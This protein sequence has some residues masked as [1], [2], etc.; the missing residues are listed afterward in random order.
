MRPEKPWQVRYKRNLQTNVL[1]S[2]DS[3]ILN[4]ISKYNP[5]IYR[6]RPRGNYSRNAKLLKDSNINIMYLIIK[7]KKLYDHYSRCRENIL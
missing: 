6:K 4:N 2:I 7:V 5:T 1:I 3:K